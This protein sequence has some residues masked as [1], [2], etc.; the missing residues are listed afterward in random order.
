MQYV[1]FRD[2][3]KSFINRKDVTSDQLD[4]FVNGGKDA[5]QL[6]QAFNFT[7]KSATLVYPS[8]GGVGVQLPSDYKSLAGDYAVRFEGTD[9]ART[10]LKGSTYANEMRRLNATA[11]LTTVA[12]ALQPIP[13]RGITFYVEFVDDAPWLFLNPEV[14]AASLLVKYISWIS[15]Y[16]SSVPDREDFLLRHGNQILLWKALEYANTF[17]SEDAKVEI[18]TEM[19][20]RGLATLLDFD[21]RMEIDGAHLDLE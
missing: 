17:E 10:P 15:D 19:A 8:N 12:S 5:L 9:G 20:N 16:S 4:F 14:A 11:P 1:T 7:K 2:L 21:S 18:N 6:T 3:V 13:T